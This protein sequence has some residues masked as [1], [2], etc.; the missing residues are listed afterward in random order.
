MY[1][2]ADSCKTDSCALGFECR[3]INGLGNFECDP[4]ECEANLC[5]ESGPY[6]LCCQ[7][8]V[9]SND[10]IIYNATT[11]NIDECACLCTDNFTGL[12]KYIQ[13]YIVVFIEQT[14]LISSF[15]DTSKD[16]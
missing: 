15:Y 4:I 3:S 13:Y 2:T 10:N 11:N 7:N 14:H 8:G 12:F 6:P 1:F 9:C 5:C 16:Y